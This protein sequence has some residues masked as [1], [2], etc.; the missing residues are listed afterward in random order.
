MPDSKIPNDCAEAEK[1]RGG[2]RAFPD[3]PPDEA[4]EHL[5]AQG[6]VLGAEVSPALLIGRILGDHYRLE[7]HIDTGGFGHVFRAVQETT[8]QLVAVKVLRPRFNKGAPSLAR[9]VARFRREMK[10]CAEL[11]HPHIVRLIDSGQTTDGLLFSVFEYVPGA[12]LAEFLRERGAITVRTTIELM[13]QVLDALICAH[14][15]GIVHRDL[16]PDNIMVSTTGSRP[17]PTVLDFGISAFIEGSLMDEFKSLT[18]TREILGTPAYAA[19]E[20]LRGAPASAKS[21]LYAWGLIFVEC[22]LGRRVCD[23]ATALEMVHRQ[24]S[25]EPVPLPRRLQE[26]WLGTILRWVLEKDATRRP[27]DAAL[28]MDRLSDERL[29]GDLVDG[30][31]Y[32]LPDGHTGFAAT[33]SPH[34]GPPSA[35][36]RGHGPGR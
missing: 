36:A 17:Q 25:P 13:G 33:P 11:H 14:G 18:M 4:W 9:Q 20:Q 28:V 12:S 16:K 15:K 2:G 19:P 22:L 30:Q 29:L 5:K 6:Q 21:D 8:G 1:R 7:S 26:H 3:A 31:G 10:A 32:L 27:G 35:R 24:L 23:A 34:E